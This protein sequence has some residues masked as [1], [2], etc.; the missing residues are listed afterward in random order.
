LSHQLHGAIGLAREYRL[1]LLTERLW[2]W[3]DEFGSQRAWQERLGRLV[4]RGGGTGGATLW[5]LVT[6]ES[7][8]A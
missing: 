5:E 4:R 3:R 8:F 2:A 7:G 6:E 1:A